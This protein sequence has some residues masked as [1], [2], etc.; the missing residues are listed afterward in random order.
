M[1]QEEHKITNYVDVD[2]V[3]IDGR[4]FISLECFLTVKS[5]HNKELY[6]LNDEVRRLQKENDDYRTLLIR[7]LQTENDA[8]R[9]LLHKMID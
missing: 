7:R 1:E 3:F 5:E 2:H 9:T 8:Y 6:I 4:Q